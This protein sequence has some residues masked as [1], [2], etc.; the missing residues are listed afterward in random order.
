MVKLMPVIIDLIR[1]PDSFKVMSTVNADG[2]PHTIVCG[3]LVVPNE[4]TLAVG[5]VWAKTTGQNL[6]RDRR[7]EFLVSEGKTAYSIVTELVDRSEDP[8]IVKKINIYLERM[9]M[10]TESV[11]LFTVKAVYDESISENTGKQVL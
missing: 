1:R 8:E 9:G 10:T 7:A 5:R 11:W 3:S 2:C 6:A 4:E